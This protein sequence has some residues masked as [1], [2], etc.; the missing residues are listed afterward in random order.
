MVTMYMDWNRLKRMLSV[1]D[2]LSSREEKFWNICF[3]S[4]FHVVDQSD[5]KDVVPRP[6]ARVSLEANTIWEREGVKWKDVFYMHVIL[7]FWNKNLKVIKQR[8]DSS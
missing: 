5:G 1:P 7:L 3:V 2:P 6:G 8:V 4:G